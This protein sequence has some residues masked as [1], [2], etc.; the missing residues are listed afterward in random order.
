MVSVDKPYEKVIPGTRPPLVKG[1]FCEVE[2]RGRP[3]K[4][5]IVI[6]R[7]ALHEG[8]VYLVNG[9]QRLERRK[10]DVAFAQSSLVC[11]SGGL[12][13][14]EILVVADPTPAIEGLLVDPEVDAALLEELIAEARGEVPLR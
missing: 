12:Q 8:H 11:L 7:S 2:L 3:R 13:K 14:G 5:L 1:M 10:V 4:G 6:P 9:E